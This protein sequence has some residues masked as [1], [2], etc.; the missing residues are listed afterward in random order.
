DR[1]AH[2]HANVRPRRELVDEVSRHALLEAV[3][4]AEQRHAARVVREEDR[5]LAR[6]VAGAD[7]VHVEPV[8]AR[9]LAARGTVR[10]TTAGEALES[11]DGEPPPRDA[12]RQDDRLPCEHV[13][14]VEMKLARGRVDA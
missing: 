11:V 4:A 2:A 13:A 9:R 14:A 5:G 6:R 3:A 12:A 1:S 10:D 8:T 7:D